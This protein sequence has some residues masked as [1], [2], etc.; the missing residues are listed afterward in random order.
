VLF[1]LSSV[2][3]GRGL[4][5]WAP[6]AL[7]LLFAAFVGIFALDVFDADLG[8]WQTLAALSI[9]LIPTGVLLLVLAIAWRWPWVG[10]GIY[11]ALGVLYNLLFTEPS[12]SVRATISGP[13]FLIAFLFMAQSRALARPDW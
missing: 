4:L 8:F 1:A 11:I 13:L 10:A 3:T 7:A 2:E 5:F 12:W 6:R 9:H